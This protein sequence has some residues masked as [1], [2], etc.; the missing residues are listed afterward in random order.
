MR[1]GLNT[2]QGFVNQFR[3]FMG[4]PMQMLSRSGLNI[5]QNMQGNPNQIIQQMMNNGQITQEQYN[6]AQGIA[7][8][9]RSNPQFMQMFKR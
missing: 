3:G 5:P 1:S 6:K 8:Q 2:M 9:M 4:N 7:Q